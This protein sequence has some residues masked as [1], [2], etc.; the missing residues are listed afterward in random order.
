MEVN[1]FTHFEVERNAV[2]VPTAEIWAANAK[3]ETCWVLLGKWVT[4]A[5]PPYKS[6]FSGTTVKRKKL[7]R[8]T[9]LWH[10]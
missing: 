10:R 8:M 3:Y 4:T 5:V 7:P 9:I 1:P 2:P 6:L